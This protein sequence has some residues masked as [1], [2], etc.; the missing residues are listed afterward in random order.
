MASRVDSFTAADLPKQAKPRRVPAAKAPPASKPV[1]AAKVVKHLTMM[2][3]LASRARLTAIELCLDGSAFT[4]TELQTP[5]RM[6]ARRV[7]DH[8]KMLC[9]VGVL[10][11]R[12]GHDKREIQ[13][14]INPGFVR[15]TE[16][17]TAIFDFGSGQLSFPKVRLGD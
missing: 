16:D 4:A 11:R 10:Q 6:S 13:Y 1:R 3:A 9:Q 17:G 5:M 7:A 15:K 8:M 2:K 12:S 14:V